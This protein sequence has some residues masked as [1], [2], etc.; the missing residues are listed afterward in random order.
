MIVSRRCNPGETA[1]VPAGLECA[2]GQNLVLLRSDG[3][4][5]FPPFLRW[6]V[7][8]PQWWE[9][10]GQHINVGAVFDSLR[11]A[12][13][14]NFRMPLP[15]LQDQ[16]AIAEVLGA[17]DD[18]ID[19]N[20][21]MNATLEAMA[22][23]LFQSWFVDF[24]P[25]RAK[26]DG[27]QPAGVDAATAALLPGAFRESEVG[28]VPD[29]WTVGR[30]GDVTTNPRRSVPAGQIAA[31]T[32]YI[33]LE[34]MPR[35]SVALGTWEV[36]ADVASG[37]SAFKKGEILFGKLRPYF[38]KVGVAPVDGV[39]STDILVVSP[40]SREWFSFALGHLSSDEIIQFTDQAST[41]T[42]MP[43]T[44]WRDVASFTVA[45]PPINLAAA[46]DAAARPMFDRIVANVHGSRTLAALRDTLLPKL[47]SGEIR[48]PEALRT[49]EAV[50]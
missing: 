9:Q 40:A 50:L 11:C 49:A 41:G 43:R 2:L 25:V 8:S 5:V 23:A 16:E 22:R 7:R 21:R 3:S 6:F 46:F 27:R 19:L 36:S 13:I 47:L 44:S 17:L 35:R 18:K 42:K 1:F 28:H 15:A 30:L 24:D 26:V 34:H 29:G 33:A 32:A 20:H 37:K 45:V 31:G 10:V 12:D 39:C 48:V 4:R 38:H 14:P